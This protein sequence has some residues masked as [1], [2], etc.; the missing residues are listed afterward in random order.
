MIAYVQGMKRL[1]AQ[2]LGLELIGVTLEWF[3]WW[4]QILPPSAAGDERLPSAHN[5]QSFNKIS[6]VHG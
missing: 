2:T 6:S 5:S 1:G 4:P 3:V